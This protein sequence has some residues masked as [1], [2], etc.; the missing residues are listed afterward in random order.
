MGLESQIREIET[1]INSLLGHLRPGCPA[2]QRA[3]LERMIAKKQSTLRRLQHK[4]LGLVRETTDEELAE[5][6][7]RL[8]Q[9]QAIPGQRAEG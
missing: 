4:H 2:S 8:A 7:E 9:R 3:S 1:A 5:A 6:R